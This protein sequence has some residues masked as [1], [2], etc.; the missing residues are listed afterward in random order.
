MPQEQYNNTMLQLQ[1]QIK[2]KLTVTVN[3]LAEKEIKPNGQA[4]VLYKNYFS[5]RT[6]AQDLPYAKD[7][8]NGYDA[9]IIFYFDFQYSYNHRDASVIDG[10]VKFGTVL[11]YFFLIWAAVR[12]CVRA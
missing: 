5:E 1:W 3:E 10:L 9:K 11:V 6:Q 8:D 2:N 4:E 12:M 7:S